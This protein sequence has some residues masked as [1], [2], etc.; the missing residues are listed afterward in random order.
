MGDLG[1]DRG[2][3]VEIFGVGDEMVRRGGKAGLLKR[4]AT[5]MLVTREIH[6]VRRVAGQAKSLAHAGRQGRG[7][8]A[9]S[10]DAID[11]AQRLTDLRDQLNEVTEKHLGIDIKIHGCESCNKSV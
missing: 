11:A 8:L 9:E 6:G 1:T 10:A 5:R 2:G 7:D 4:T 3:S